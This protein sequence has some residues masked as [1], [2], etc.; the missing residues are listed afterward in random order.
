MVKKVKSIL[1]N[2][3]VCNL[4]VEK[5]S[6]A[7]ALEKQ[8]GIEWGFNQEHTF[9]PY[10]YLRACISETITVPAG[11]HLPIPTGIYLQFTDPQYIA[12]VTT[13][14]DVL[15]E[16]GLSILSAPKS[17]YKASYKGLKYGSTFSFISPGKN[18]NLSPASTA[19]LVK[20]ILFTFSSIK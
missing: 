13:Y 7:L 1:Q 14:H 18:P 20:I 6:N 10:F 9:D 19:G 17:S 4:L 8:H 5:S 11:K 15:F 3:K 2:S 12:E 16:Q